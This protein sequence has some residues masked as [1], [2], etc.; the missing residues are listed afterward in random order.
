MIYVE[1]R[2]KIA[3]VRACVRAC[4]CVCARGRELGG[5]I[6]RLCMRVCMR[7]V[8]ASGCVC[9]LVRMRVHSCVFIYGQMPYNFTA[10]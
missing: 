2:N 1:C 9:L 10:R 5:K 8:T 6:V 4:A 7:G 3:C